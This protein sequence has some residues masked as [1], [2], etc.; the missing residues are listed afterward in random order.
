MSV[1]YVCHKVTEIIKQQIL[2]GWARLKVQKQIICFA[3]QLRTIK[4]CWFSRNVFI[5]THP[6]KPN[7]KQ[8]IKKYQGF[9]NPI[10]T[11]TFKYQLKLFLGH[12]NRKRCFV[13]VLC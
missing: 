7:K 13:A 2:V 6:R 1:N 8:L 4:G 12:L 3:E 11:K 10:I 5:S 9:V